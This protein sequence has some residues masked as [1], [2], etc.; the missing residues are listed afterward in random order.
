MKLSCNREHLSALFSLAAAVASVK[1]I[2]AVLQN[3]KME[4]LQKQA[5]LS[6][7]DMDISI[8]LT[9]DKVE[10]ADTGSVILPTRLFSKILQESK[11]DILV[12]ETDGNTLKIR[13]ER[14]YYSIPT[15]SVED[16]PDI[17]SFDFDSYHTVTGNVLQEHIRRTRFAIDTN[18]TKYALCGV[19]FE[20]TEGR[21][22]TVA[23]DGRRLA[24]QEGQA[25]SFGGHFSEN[26]AI[27]PIKTLGLVEKAIGLTAEPIKININD[28]K[29]YFATSNITISSRLVEGRFPRWKNIIPNK[30]DRVKVDLMDGSFLECVRQAEVV[31]TDNQPGINLNFIKGKLEISASA[32]EKGNSKIE[33]PIAYDFSE[34]GVKLD[35]R[36]LIDFL[37]GL[38]SD[39]IISLYLKSEQ[40]VLFETN[41]G[42]SYILMPLS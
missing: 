14:S 9:L 28:S 35:P 5:I 11:D 37:R 29:I 8:R 16:F 12:F 31:T 41:D 40:S 6:A 19:L 2:K 33:L 42:Y 10:V 38:Q 30:S 25:E 4:V 20:L 39:T 22:G 36:F 3:V 26:S 24:N 7:T 13:G 17:P 18:N 1:D 27:V 23:T 34:I 21:I 32:S 15:Q